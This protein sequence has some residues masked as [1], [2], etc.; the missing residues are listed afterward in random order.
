M[1][2]QADTTKG[3]KTYREYAAD[4]IRLAQSVDPK[5]REAKMAQAKTPRRG[6]TFGRSDAMPTR[7]NHTEGFARRYSAN[8]IK[9]GRI[10]RPVQPSVFR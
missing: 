1:G 8:A 2:Q 5:D 3:A 10:I 9:P 7:R 6:V 4:F